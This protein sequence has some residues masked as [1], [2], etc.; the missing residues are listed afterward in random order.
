MYIEHFTDAELKGFLLYIRGWQDEGCNITSSYTH[1]NCKR[2][3]VRRTGKNEAGKNFDETYILYFTDFKCMISAE[4]YRKKWAEYVISLI[5]SREA[6]GDTTLSSKKYRE[7]YNTN[8]K[9]QEGEEIKIIKRKFD[10]S[11]LK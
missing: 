6:L 4:T 1:I 2:L 9:A 11:L 8:I 7:E 10:N 5:E 3:F